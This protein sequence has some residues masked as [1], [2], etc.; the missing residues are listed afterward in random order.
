MNE[1]GLDNFY[2]IIPINANKCLLKLMGLK[3]VMLLWLLWTTF[4]KMLL[5][6]IFHSISVEGFKILKIKLNF[7]KPNYVYSLLYMVTVVTCPFNDFHPK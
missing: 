7:M 2:W 5:R 6:I 3:P 4:D 1:P